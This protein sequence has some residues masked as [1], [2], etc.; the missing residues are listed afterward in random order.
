MTFECHE[1]ISKFISSRCSL[2]PEIVIV[3]GSGLSK[4]VDQVESQTI[5]KFSEIE[6]FPQL[7]GMVFVNFSFFVQVEGHQ[8]NLVL[9]YL[10]EKAVAVLQG[11]AHA[12]EGFSMTE[13]NFKYL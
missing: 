1:E 10:G 5:I 2:K 12:Y 4:I 6:G 11:R 13:V 8:G 7:T 9:G 3:C